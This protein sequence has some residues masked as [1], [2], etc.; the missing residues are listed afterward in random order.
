MLVEPG[1]HFFTT[2]GPIIVA[3]VKYYLGTPSLEILQ[4]L[5][6]LYLKVFYGES[7]N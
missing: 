1:I 6:V 3:H 5:R 7:D 4:Y 2:N